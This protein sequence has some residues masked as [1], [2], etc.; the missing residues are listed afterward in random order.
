LKSLLGNFTLSS[1]KYLPFQLGKCGN[2]RSYFHS[3]F[4]VLS[5]EFHQNSI[6][7][8]HKNFLVT[9][10]KFP[11]LSHHQFQVIAGISVFFICTSVISFCL[12]TLPGLRVEIP[13]S[14]FNLTSANLS[15]ILQ[16]T[17][18]TLPPSA[19]TEADLI[20]STYRSTHRYSVGKVVLCC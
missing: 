20:T 18:T 7:D 5:A 11:F 17:A 9:S 12:K 6:N 16:A 1:G 2:S 14:T 4:S 13:P 10:T 19:T 3:E 8:K 15:D